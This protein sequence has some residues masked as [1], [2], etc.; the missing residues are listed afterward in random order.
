MTLLKPPIPISDLHSGIDED[1]LHTIIKL[2]NE[3]RGHTDTIEDGWRGLGSFKPDYRSIGKVLDLM[4]HVPGL[5]PI[6]YISPLFEGGFTLEWDSYGWSYA[7]S[8]RNV[9]SIGFFG[10]KIVEAM[11]TRGTEATVPKDETDIFT[12]KR[13]DDFLIDCVRKTLKGPWSK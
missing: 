10:V 3:M 5:A 2:T 9:S 8:V 7:M 11:T 6:L 1:E 4:F 13:V 12:F